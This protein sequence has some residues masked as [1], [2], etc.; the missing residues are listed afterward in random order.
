MCV[1]VGCFHCKCDV[2]HMMV[3]LE[4]SYGF[5]RGVGSCFMKWPYVVQCNRTDH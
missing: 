5:V 4:A 2:V 1:D 3:A